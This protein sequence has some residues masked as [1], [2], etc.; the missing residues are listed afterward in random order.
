MKGIS[1]ECG[2]VVSRGYNILLT[3]SRNFSWNYGDASRGKAV[4]LVFF[5]V[6]NHFLIASKVLSP[7]MTKSLKRPVI[8]HW[9]N[10]CLLSLFLRISCKQ[11]VKVV[12]N[13]FTFCGTDGAEQVEQFDVDKMRSYFTSA[14]WNETYFEQKYNS[15]HKQI[16]LTDAF[17]YTTRNI[18]LDA[19]IFFKDFTGGI[20]FY[21]IMLY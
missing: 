14:N 8:Y 12:V 3:L 2:V 4:L 17:K 7:L 11:G 15:K 20:K 5:V 18:L 19:K 9:P 16:L 1:R 13:N 21:C 10:N 6:F